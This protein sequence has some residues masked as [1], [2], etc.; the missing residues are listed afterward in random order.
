MKI[1]KLNNKTKYTVVISLF[2]SLLFILWLHFEFN[3]MYYTHGY[4]I[5]RREW[6][7]V[8][9]LL[10]PSG[11]LG[12][13]FG[14]IGV[15]LVYIGLLYHVRKVHKAKL[16]KFL[17]VQTWLLIHIATSI[18]GG[19]LVIFHASALFKNLSGSVTMIL[20]LIVLITGFLLALFKT[21]PK[22]RKI[23]YWLHYYGTFSMMIALSIHA[24]YF[25]YLGFRWIF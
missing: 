15:I 5:R 19:M 3:I 11:N 13:G 6:G 7:A 20:F 24:L 22:T 12:H 1:K 2:V 23:I 10:R 21:K 9:K 17:S 25:I 8:H 16:K 14:I 18:V 4:D